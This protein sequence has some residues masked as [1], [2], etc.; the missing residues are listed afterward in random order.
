MAKIAETSSNLSQNDTLCM[1]QDEEMFRAKSEIARLKLEALRN[2]IRLETENFAKTISSQIRA[3]AYVNGALN[4]STS[5]VFEDSPEKYACVDF[6][7]DP[8]YICSFMKK[9]ISFQDNQR[10]DN[11][12]DGCVNKFLASEREDKTKAYTSIRFDSL[13][14]LW[15]ID[16]EGK[17]SM[18]DKPI[19]SSNKKPK[20]ISVQEAEQPMIPFLGK[21]LRTDL[22]KNNLACKSSNQSISYYQR[23][24][25]QNE[26]KLVGNME[27]I[28]PAHHCILDFAITDRYLA[29]AS[30]DFKIRIY[31]LIT[32]KLDFSG[33]IEGLATSICLFENLEPKLEISSTDRLGTDF[34]YIALGMVNS[35]VVYKY[36]FRYKAMSHLATIP[37]H[38]SHVG[39]QRITDLKFWKRRRSFKEYQFHYPTVYLA[40]AVNKKLS[41][42]NIPSRRKN[43]V[44]DHNKPIV[45]I[46]EIVIGGHNSIAIIN[47]L[48]KTVLSQTEEVRKE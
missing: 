6:A 10:D 35:T 24:N 32:K 30:T 43:N 47:S 40:I 20:E 12:K 2:T 13:S 17:V 34:T 3:V 27:K 9:E 14:N 44:T 22:L 45:P 11:Q 38:P 16:V 18:W 33:Y 1:R 23:E 19:G 5:L 25:G 15:L 28:I 26:M 8:K 39:D 48:D 42:R 41:I 29:T 21:M 7:A 46:M 36:D 37:G 4:K 31:D